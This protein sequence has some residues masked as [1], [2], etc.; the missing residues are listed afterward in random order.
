MAGYGDAV[1]SEQSMPDA[2]PFVLGVHGVPGGAFNPRPKHHAMP[3]LQM[4]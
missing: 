4:M 1:Q 2:E 3:A